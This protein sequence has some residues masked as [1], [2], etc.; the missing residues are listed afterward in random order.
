MSQNNSDSG[1]GSYSRR[2]VFRT[3]SSLGVGAV[4]VPGTVSANSQ[5]SSNKSDGQEE[6]PTDI[7]GTE[8]P[9]KTDR[10][11]G[12]NVRVV[13]NDELPI[14]SEAFGRDGVT[15]ASLPECIGFP[16]KGYLEAQICPEDNGSVTASVGVF[17]VARDTVT[18]S[19]G[20]VKKTSSFKAPLPAVPGT[21]HEVTYTWNSNWSGTDLTYLS[22]DVE[23]EKWEFG[24]G[25]STVIDF[26]KVVV[27]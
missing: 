24:S 6:V 27:S 1:E 9:E 14:P 8:N 23:L 17:G 5:S 21:L 20:S 7:E 11:F 19:P 2:K 10:G 22:L 16:I 4:L 15:V 13:S 3:V 12:E 18:L 26:F 25:W